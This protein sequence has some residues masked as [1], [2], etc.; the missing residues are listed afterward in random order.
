MVAVSTSVNIKVARLFAHVG[1]AICYKLTIRLA[2]MSMNV[3][4]RRVAVRKSVQT[5]Q[6][7]THVGVAM[8]FCSIKMDA[9]AMASIKTLILKF[10]RSTIQHLIVEEYILLN[11]YKTSPKKL[12]QVRLR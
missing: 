8:D 7:D 3:L 9:A 2:L 10:M 4:P 6:E 11:G 5:T 12:Q 1:V